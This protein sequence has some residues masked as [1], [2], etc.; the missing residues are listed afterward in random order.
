M[1]TLGTHLV[2]EATAAAAAEAAAAALVAYKR[3]DSRASH[4][5]PAHIS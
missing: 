1:H 4:T 5:D 2:V 3:V